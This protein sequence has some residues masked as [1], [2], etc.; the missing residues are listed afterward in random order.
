MSAY[1]GPEISNDGLVFH[2]DMGNTNKSWKGKPTNNIISSQGI[3]GLQ[4]ITYTYVGEEAGWKKYSISGTWSSGTYPWSLRINNTTFTGGVAYSARILFKCNCREKYASLGTLGVNYVNDPNMVSGGTKYSTDLGYDDDGLLIT[5][6]KTD[7]LIYSTGYANPTTNQPGYIHSKPV[8]DGTTFNSSSDFIWVKEIQVEEGAFTTPYVNG[9][10]SNTQTILD[11][12][13]QNII[14]SSN[15][16]YNS[17]NTFELDGTDDYFETDR[18]AGTGTSTASVSWSI[19]TKPNSSAGNIMSMS[20]VNPQGSWNMPPIAADGGKFRGKIWS[21]RFLYSD[22]YTQGQWYLITLVFN[23]NA[24]STERYQRLFVNGEMVD[25]QVGISY[26]SSNTD[27]YLYFGQSNPGADNQGYY[28]GEIGKVQVYNMAL[29]PQ[30][31]KNNYLATKS[32]Y[33]L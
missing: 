12:T 13:G 19:W 15:L 32:R 1:S 16:S 4:G 9:T 33:G 10:R 31:V 26:S 21:N 17:D 2:F 5:E 29:S 27:N 25:E 22:L 18:I 30:E 23:Y 6:L 11:M 24:T 28:A 14:T 3:A 8:S 20:S 7:G